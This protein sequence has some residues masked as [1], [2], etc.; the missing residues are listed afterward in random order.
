MILGI[1]P[2]ATLVG[3]CHQGQH[4][5]A[6]DN[7]V[8]APLLAGIRQPKLYAVANRRYALSKISHT[9][10]G[11]DIFAPAAGYLSKGLEPSRLGPRVKYFKKVLLPAIR[12]GKDSLEGR[13]IGFDRFGNTM[14]NLPDEETRRLKRYVRVR[15]QLK[16]QVLGNLRNSYNAVASGTP[17][18]VIWKSRSSGNCSESGIRSEEVPPQG[19]RGG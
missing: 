11:R 17:L 10:H 16:K 4:F 2:L 12:K 7:G 9:F 5:L 19:W 8:L 15:V 13:I 6:P 1:N 18:A 3:L 14:T